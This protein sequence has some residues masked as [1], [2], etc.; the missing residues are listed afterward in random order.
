LQR[1]RTRLRAS[2]EQELRI[3][4]SS[5][6]KELLSKSRIDLISYRDLG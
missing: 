4:T 2:R 5:E 1:I 6:T 3:L